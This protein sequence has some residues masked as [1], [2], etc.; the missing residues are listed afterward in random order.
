MLINLLGIRNL[1]DVLSHLAPRDLPPD[2]RDYRGGKVPTTDDPRVPLAQEEAARLATMLL[3]GGGSAVRGGAAVARAGAE[4]MYELLARLLQ[5][6]EVP[7]HVVDKLRVRLYSTDKGLT[8]I[9]RDRAINLARGDPIG[10]HVE[11]GP[12]FGPVRTAGRELGTADP[13][14]TAGYVEFDAP[15][16]LRPTFGFSARKTGVIPAKAPLRIDQLNPTFVRPL[17]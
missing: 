4:G 13:D 9:L 11:V 2:V 15:A 12:N 8:G 3:P 7:S 1:V 16:E 6:R 14:K 17:W 10:V 5:S